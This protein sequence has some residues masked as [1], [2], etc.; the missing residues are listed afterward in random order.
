MSK[1]TAGQIMTGSI[2]S[3]PVNHVCQESHAENRKRA[4]A[5]SK[6][7]AQGASTKTISALYDPVIW[8][9]RSLER[10]YKLSELL[11]RYTFLTSVV[12]IEFACAHT[13]TPKLHRP[14]SSWLL[15][16]LMQDRVMSQLSVRKQE[17]SLP[18]IHLPKC[19]NSSGF[20]SI[21]GLS[22]KG[23]LSLHLSQA[24]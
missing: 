14:N 12:L 15:E 6:A 17:A 1:L 7:V 8:P 19:A 18:T 5:A 2:W 4:P 10:R 9:Y 21:S 20:I 22:R 16:C 3:L 24:F 23:S 11:D 13:M